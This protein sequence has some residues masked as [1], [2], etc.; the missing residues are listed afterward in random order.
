MKTDKMIALVGAIALTVTAGI[1]A[2]RDK[3]ETKPAADA[4]KLFPDDVLCKGKSVEVRRS[5]VD[6]AFVQFKANLTAR[7]QPFPE[8]RREQVETQLLDRLVV[9]KLLV[10]RATDEDR[11]RAKTLAEKFEGDTRKQAGSD[12]SFERQLL[13]MGFSAAQFR[14]QVVER[15]ICEEVVERELKAKVSITDEQAKKFYDENGDQFERP[16]MVRASHIL[17]STRDAVSGQEANAEKKKEKKAQ[18]EKILE[19]ARKGEDFAALAKEFSEDPGS[20]DKGGEYT[21]PRGQMVPEFETAAFGL[22]TNEISDIVTTQFGYH[23]IKLSEKMPAQKVEYASTEK[24]LKEH[25]AKQ[26]VQK[27][28]PPFLEK[29]K[30]EANLEYLHGAKPPVESPVEVPAGKPAATPGDAKP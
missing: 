9:T 19:R 2:E 20:K 11:A 18:T 22:K 23:I 4:K 5:Q 12:D 7:G 21:F 3:P 15:A 28:L 6:E 14:E 17:I 27:Q 8:E 24:E 13:A 10:N 26:E 30:T 1:A 25:L 16:E 29:L